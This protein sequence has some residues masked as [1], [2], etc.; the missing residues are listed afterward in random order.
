LNL[1]QI[2]LKEKG[3][4]P[5]N[6]DISGF[7][8]KKEIHSLIDQL[9]DYSAKLS[10]RDKSFAHK[11]SSWRLDT[12]VLPYHCT[13]SIILVGLLLLYG[14]YCCIAYDFFRKDYIA[15]FNAL[16]AE[17]NQIENA[18]PHYVQAAV[19]YTKLQ[20]NLQKIIKDNLNSGQL[21]L[22]NDQGDNLRKWFNQNTSSW[23][24]LKKGVSIDYCNAT[25]EHISPFDC[26]DKHDFSNPSDHGYGQIRDLYVNVN[27][28]RRAGVLD[29]D[30][31][32]LFQMQLTSS[33]HFI[34]GKTFIDQFLGYGMLK[35]SIELFTEQDSYEL[36][37]LQKARKLLK[38]HF[39]DGLP[40]LSIDGEVLITCSVY[41]HMINLKKIPVQSPL[42]PVFFMLGSRAGSEAFIKKRFTFI[43]EQAQKGI[44]VEPKGFSINNFLIMRNRFFRIL[45]GSIAKSYAVFRKADTGML[46]AYVI[47]DLEEYRLIKGCYPGNVSQLREAGLTSQLPDDP[48]SDSKII[49]RNDGQRAI[50][51]ALGQNGKD[52]GGYKNDKDCDETRD[53]IIFWQRP[54]KEEPTAVP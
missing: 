39:P 29:M 34:K 17:P 12:K 37:D 18:W 13:F 42:N 52:D 30:W 33:K 28:G 21:N 35:R 54:L 10:G 46:A 1:Y 38:A 6:I 4:K 22:T 11:F 31:F 23:E 25:Y 32:D 43:L 36:E 44:E 24:S 50:L 20:E 40:L 48:D 5:L 15:Q 2:H 53:D 9:R 14:S 16:G 49:Y 45:E 26:M 7:Y 47:F 41:G 19:N 3:K 51:Y 27:A 8:K